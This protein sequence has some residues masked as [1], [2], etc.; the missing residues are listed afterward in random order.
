VEHSLEPLK[1][2]IDE[3]LNG[4][5]RQARKVLQISMLIEDGEKK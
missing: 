3:G 5:C 2:A 1:M 4:K